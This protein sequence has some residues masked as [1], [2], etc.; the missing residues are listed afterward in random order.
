MKVNGNGFS[1]E[2]LGLLVMVFFREDTVEPV[3]EFEFGVTSRG[4][5][6]HIILSMLVENGFL[7]KRES[8]YFCTKKS[9]RILILNFSEKIKDF[10]KI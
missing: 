6:C 10:V 4:K 1:S 7:E 5:N 3:R 2:E 9:K 8:I